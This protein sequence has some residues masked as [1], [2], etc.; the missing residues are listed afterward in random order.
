MFAV[1][2]EFEDLALSFFDSD[3][4][5]RNAFQNSRCPRWFESGIDFGSREAKLEVV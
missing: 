2:S 1:L 5:V 3:L 4:A